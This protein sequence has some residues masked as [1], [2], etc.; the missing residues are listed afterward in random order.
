VLALGLV[1]ATVACGGDDGGS[2]KGTPAAPSEVKVTDK[3]DGQDVRVAKGGKLIVTLD[4]NRTTGF[5]W[6]V[7]DAA[8]PPLAAQVDQRYDA[9][10][11]PPGTGGTE[12]YTFTAASAGN[13]ILRLTYQRSF[14]PATTP[15]GRTFTLKVTVE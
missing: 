4:S 14:E 2:S 8:A 5:A 1:V 6:K 3:Q 15:P 7:A 10:S 9:Q 12:V 13:A 11:G